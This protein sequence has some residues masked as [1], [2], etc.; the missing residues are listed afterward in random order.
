MAAA[1]YEEI[2]YPVKEY[3]TRLKEEH[4]RNTS[5]FFEELVQRSGVDVTANAELARKIHQQEKQV[6][7]QNSRLSLRLF[8]RN[9]LILIAL[10][11]GIVVLLYLLP[12]FWDDAPDCGIEQKFAGIAGGAMTV[13]LILIFFVL[14]KKIRLLK[15]KVDEDQKLLNAAVD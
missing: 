8:L 15:E 2:P 5:D 4:A 1:D 14:R 11:G 3:A 7:L 9:L 6:A 10:A 12:L 13:S